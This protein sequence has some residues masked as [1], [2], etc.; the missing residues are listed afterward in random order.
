MGGRKIIIFIFLVGIL[1]FGK[2][3][4]LSAQSLIDI[5]IK[6][7]KA[8]N[9]EEA[10]EI[11]TKAKSQQPDSSLIAFYLGLTFKQMGNFREATGQFKEALRLSPPANDA[12][13]ELIE[14]LYFL[15]EIKEAKDWMNKAEKEGVKPGRLSYLKGLIL[16]K[17]REEKGA[18]K[19]F[20]K[21][22]ELDSSL[23]QASDIQIARIYARQKRFPEA[24]ES[25]KAVISVDPASET[26]SFAKEYEDALARSVKK[27]KPWSVIAGVTYQFDDNVVLK[28][29]RRIPDLNI[30]GEKDSSIVTT[31]RFIYTPLLKEPWVFTGQYTSYTNTY[32][33]NHKVNLI[34]Q[35]VSLTPGYNFNRGV[36]TLPVS[37]SYL[38]LREKEYMHLTQTRPTVYLMISPD[39]IV[40]LSTGYIRREMLRSPP[41]HDRNEE[42]DGNI[43][44]LS[45]GYLRPFKGGKG[46]FYFHYEFSDDNTE[47][48]NWENIGNRFTLGLILPIVE[49]VSLS[50]SGDI[51]LQDYRHT[52][53][54]YG[55]ERSDRIYYGSTGIRWEMLKGLKLNL[56]YGHTR[57]DSNIDVYEY[58]RNVVQLGVE[59]TF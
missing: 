29:S 33:N 26:A 46:L 13:P 40:Q 17:E 10:L 25:L 1:M 30:S 50:L 9:Y 36:F 57:A 32:F 16:L 14:T 53:T 59:Y 48:K 37:F 3:E 31:L 21:A 8:E 4:D 55:M 12:Y 47:G 51:L 2:T 23:S 28:P 41:N 24:K 27:Y 15:N 39:H 20:K 49:K 19:A 35:S 18:L 43:W 56:Q 11:L 7:Y 38:W 52:H 45:P 54:F 5:G 22:K 58:R 42:R 6:E 34:N 44:S